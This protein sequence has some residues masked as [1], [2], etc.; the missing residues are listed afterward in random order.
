MFIY[1][2]LKLRQIIILTSIWVLIYVYLTF[3]NK[4]VERQQ[5]QNISS[6][7]NTVR[8][9]FNP[10]ALFYNQIRPASAINWAAVVCGLSAYLRIMLRHKKVEIAGSQINTGG[11]VWTTTD[12]REDIRGQHGHQV[13]IRTRNG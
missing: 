13:Q 5:F 12:H 9:M 7:K 10:W 6:C 4:V 2:I 1:I 11:T 3:S 8:Y